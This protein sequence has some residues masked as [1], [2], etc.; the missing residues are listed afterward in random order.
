MNP[1]LVVSYLVAA[2][3]EIG[4][5]L[6][7]GFWLARRFH[8]HWVVFGYGF[9]VFLL[10]QVITRV[11]AVQVIS[12]LFGKQLTATPE[13]TVIW[14]AVLALTAGLFEEVGRWL[15]YRWF[16]RREPRTWANA[17]LYG[18]GHAACESIILVGLAVLLAMVNY[19]VLSTMSADTIAAMPAAQQTQVKDALQIFAG[20]AGWEPLLGAVERVFTLAFHVSASVLVLQAFTRRN[21]LWLLLAIGWHALVDF[22]IVIFQSTVKNTLLTEALIGL[23]AI[24][25]LVIILRLRPSH[26]DAVTAEAAPLLSLDPAEGAGAEANAARLSFAPAGSVEPPVAPPQPAESSPAEPGTAPTPGAPGPNPPA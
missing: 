10:S 11:P 4:F 25:S 3:V 12:S 16:F 9:V 14:F 15:G 23:V 17:L 24:L 2:A 8:L 1:V 5:P 20:L 21:N 7:V 19:V 6:L 26:P 13:I 18:T 22:G